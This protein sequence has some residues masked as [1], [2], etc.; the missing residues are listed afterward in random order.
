MKS[1]QF[2][3]MINHCADALRDDYVI[4]YTLTHRLISSDDMA[5]YRLNLTI[6]SK[7]NN[8]TSDF[9]HYVA[10]DD[11]MTE[12]IAQVI[13]Y[14]QFND[15]VPYRVRDVVNVYI[16]GFICAGGLL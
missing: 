6:V 14:L 9:C 3:N 13:S 15:G 8:V 2:V 11:N 16:A 5:R 7:C 4:K 10:R 12:V 1:E